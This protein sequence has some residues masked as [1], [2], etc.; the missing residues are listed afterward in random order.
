MSVREMR[1]PEGMGMPEVH[2]R[3]TGSAGENAVWGSGWE[4]GVPGAIGGALGA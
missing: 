1:D 2:P 3:E 4:M